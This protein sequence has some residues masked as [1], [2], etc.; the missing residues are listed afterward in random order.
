MSEQTNEVTR[1]LHAWRGGDDQALEALTPLVYDELHRLAHL[2]MK[3]ERDGH[4]LQ[5][6]ALVHEA[7]ARLVKAGVDWQDRVHF[8][9]VAS[10][11]M[12]RIL[13]D[14]AKAL[15]ANKRGGDQVHLPINEELVGEE[16]SWDLVDLDHAL[17]RLE[18]LAPRQ[19]R[20]IEL[21]FFAGLTNEEVAQALDISTST[22]RGDIRLAK[23]WI[24]RELSS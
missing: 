10:K 1:L 8:Y 6:T 21:R 11:A 3:K 14:H 2:H 4:T 7:Y 15:R 12:R 17:S 22:A 19:V 9:S 16:Q 18:Q 13:V 23:A 24:H 20:A 5:T